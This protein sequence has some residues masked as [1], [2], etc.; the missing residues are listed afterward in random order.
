ME[1]ATRA[2]GGLTGPLK[3]AAGVHSGQFSTLRFPRWDTGILSAHLHPHNIL[4][5][6]SGVQ[7]EDPS[8][9]GP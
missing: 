8:P 6:D 3:E 5:Q 4:K 1:V 9:T 7:L 2:G